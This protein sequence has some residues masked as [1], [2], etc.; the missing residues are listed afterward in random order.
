MSKGKRPKYWLK[1]T[2][3]RFTQRRT[4]GGVAFENEYGSLNLVLNPGVVLSYNDE[5]FLTLVPFDENNK[6]YIP[7]S[8]RDNDASGGNEDDIPF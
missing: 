2:D 1:I 4:V 7:T 8:T 5:F 6:P 3:K